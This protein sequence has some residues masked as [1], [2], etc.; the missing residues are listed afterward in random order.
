MALNYSVLKLQRRLT[1]RYSSSKTFRILASPYRET[2]KTFIWKRLIREQ[3]R[4]DGIKGAAK[5]V[6][7]S[8][9]FCAM[10]TRV[11]QGLKSLRENQKESVDSAPR[12]SGETAPLRG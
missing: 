10:P 4:I 3:L 7:I 5:Q 9:R 1:L 2:S 11:H 12:H 8:I 6:A